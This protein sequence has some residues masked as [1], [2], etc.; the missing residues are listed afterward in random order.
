[1]LHALMSQGRLIGLYSDYEMC[2]QTLEGLVQ[3]R[4]VMRNNITIKSYYENSMM[5]GRYDVECGDNLNTKNVIT[6]NI[7]E[8]E[9]TMS[10]SD[11]DTETRKRV[12]EEKKKRADLQYEITK[13]KKEKERL[14][15]S[16]RMFEVD[17]DLYKRFKKVLDKNPQ[18]EIPELFQDKYPLM[19]RLEHDNMLT[20]ENFHANYKPKTIESGYTNMFNS[21]P[22]GVPIINKLNE[23]HNNI[24]ETETETEDED[25]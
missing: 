11:M 8:D 12:D 5:T 23:I 4:F 14:E 2:T 21:V 7:S 1:M 6:N 25:D 15:E 22:V 20:W 3:N 10:E 19:Q 18:F 17:L 16:Q 13:A 24:S 9:T